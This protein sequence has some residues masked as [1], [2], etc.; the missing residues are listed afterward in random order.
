VADDLKKRMKHPQ[1]RQ[2]YNYAIAASNLSWQV[3]SMREAKGMTLNDVAQASGVS[4]I[5]LVA[6]ENFN[7]DKLT[8]EDIAKISNVFDVA[9]V[10]KFAARAFA[11][12][13]ENIC[14]PPFEEE[15][16]AIH[17]AAQKDETVEIKIT[18]DD[19]V[20][21][22]VG[23]LHTL[24]S[25]LVNKDLTKVREWLGTLDVPSEGTYNP[26]KNLAYYCHEAIVAL[27]DKQQSDS[28]NV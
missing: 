27:H 22:R 11:I 19:M 9:A 10:V 2:G 12:E 3:K 1:F 13:H 21:V 5:K 14:P 24:L 6:L 25:T 4:M 23:D 17:E 16:K 20:N 28:K 8:T 7:L 15:A 18:S 26:I